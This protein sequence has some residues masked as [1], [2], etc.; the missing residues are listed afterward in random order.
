MWL[1]PR[2]LAKERL[3]VY[4]IWGE[5]GNMTSRQRRRS[6]LRFCFFFV[7]LVTAFLDFFCIF[8]MFSCALGLFRYFEV[9]GRHEDATQLCSLS[10]ALLTLYSCMLVSIDGCWTCLWE[11]SRYS[12]RLLD[13]D[14]D[15]ELTMW[16]CVYVTISL[17]YVRLVTRYLVVIIRKVIWRHITQ[18]IHGR[19]LLTAQHLIE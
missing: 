5:N 9:V 6:G 11:R 17:R 10:D 4:V 7:D 13:S 8:L 3:Y 2:L 1:R 18:V 12:S 19:L 15:Q 16:R 14:Y